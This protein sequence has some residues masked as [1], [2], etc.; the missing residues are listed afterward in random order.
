MKRETRLAIYWYLTI[1]QR[2]PGFFRFLTKGHVDPKEHVE[3]MNILKSMHIFMEN[4]FPSLKNPKNPETQTLVRDFLKRYTAFDKNLA[5]QHVKDGKLTVAQPTDDD[6]SST[7]DYTR[8][9]YVNEI[10]SLGNNLEL[11]F[12]QSYGLKDRSKK[13]D[14]NFVRVPPPT[15]K[16]ILVA[17]FIEYL[18]LE[19]TDEE[20]REVIR[21]EYGNMGWKDILTRS[22]ESMKKG[23]MAFLD[24]LTTCTKEITSKR[25]AEDMEDRRVKQLKKRH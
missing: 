6:G 2:V 11:E 10:R 14:S 25:K 4:M 3:S 18:W 13:K 21:F 7:A 20:T 19:Y 1:F 17:Y 8:M 15:L 23:N 5:I 9:Y 16:E 24:I 12:R 22:A